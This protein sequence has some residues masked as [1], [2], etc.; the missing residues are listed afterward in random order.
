VRLRETAL[1]DTKVSAEGGGGGASGTGAEIPLQPLEKIMVS[2][3]VPL[4]SMDVHGGADLHRQP[5]ER[6]CHAGAGR[7][8]KEAVTPWGA[9]AGPSSC[10]DRW[11]HGERSPR[12]SRLAGRAC[13]PMGDPCWS[14]LLLK[15]CTPWEGPTLEQ[16]VENCLL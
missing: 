1:A 2:Q 15:D 14:S 5:M 4:Q 10:Q 12:W 6:G 8:S 13:D 3:V 7:C 11:T 16:F 9:H